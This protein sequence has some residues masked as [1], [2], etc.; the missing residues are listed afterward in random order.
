MSSAF[1]IFYNNGLFNFICVIYVPNNTTQFNLKCSGEI[2]F[3]LDETRVKPQ[4]GFVMPG[5]YL[6]GQGVLKETILSH[7]T[8]QR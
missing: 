8:V 1:L 2:F 5:V 6:T 3:V 4:S 7:A